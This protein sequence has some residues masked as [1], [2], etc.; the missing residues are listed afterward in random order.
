ML[1]LAPAFSVLPVEHAGALALFT[2]CS[3]MEMAEKMSSAAFLTISLAMCAELHFA[4]VLLALRS[5]AAFWLAAEER[6]APPHKPPCTPG[7]GRWA[8]IPAGLCP[9]TGWVAALLPAEPALR[10]HQTQLLL[11][12][13]PSLLEGRQGAP[14]ASLPAALHPRS[15]LLPAGC[16]GEDGCRREGAGCGRERAECWGGREG[17]P[18]P[19]REEKEDQMPASGTTNPPLQPPP[20]STAGTSPMPSAR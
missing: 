16:C 13:S 7:T 9:R 4:V 3:K 20:R 12:P 19:P 10:R 11:V 6:L 5:R 2:A 8:G 17:D 18:V 15:S 14:G 1:P